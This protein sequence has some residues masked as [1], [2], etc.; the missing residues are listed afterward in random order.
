MG[1]GVFRCCQQ[2]KWIFCPHQRILLVA[3]ALQ[4]TELRKR[5]IVMSGVLQFNLYNSSTQVWTTILFLNKT[6]R[7][8]GLKMMSYV[9]GA[10]LL[11]WWTHSHE[12]R[13]IKRFML[14]HTKAHS[15]K[16][17]SAWATW[18]QTNRVRTSFPDD[19]NS[20]QYFWNVFQF[21]FTKTKNKQ[22]QPMFLSDAQGH[23]SPRY[24]GN[25]RNNT[26]WF[27]F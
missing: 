23:I 17:Q 14:L 6:Q 4:L 12:G 25:M 3:L 9:T 27:C 2:R 13:W 21:P 15:S 19:S 18:K 11:F 22:Q 10:S 24:S 5:F 8:N 7:P 1:F 16:L 20:M 26:F